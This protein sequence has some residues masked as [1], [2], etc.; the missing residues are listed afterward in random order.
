MRFGD[1]AVCL[2][3]NATAAGIELRHAVTE[4]GFLGAPV[5]DYQQSG[6]DNGTLLLSFC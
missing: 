2:M 1:F 5:N 4:L 6:V 3:H